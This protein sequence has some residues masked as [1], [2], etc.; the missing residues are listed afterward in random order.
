MTCAVVY[1]GIGFK[2]EQ[3]GSYI[4]GHRILQLLNDLSETVKYFMQQG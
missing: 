3:I 2:R 4:N 1:G